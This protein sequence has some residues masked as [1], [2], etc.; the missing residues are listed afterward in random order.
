MKSKIIS[1]TIAAVY[2]VLAYMM[3]GGE[4]AFRLL[5]FLVLPIACIWFSEEMGGYTGFIGFFKPYI[6]QKT[7]GCV[8][9]LFGWILLTLPI[10]IGLVLF[11]SRS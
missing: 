9:E 8:V 6:T 3:G 4:F 2:L 1:G 5:L 10:M 11:F 7:P